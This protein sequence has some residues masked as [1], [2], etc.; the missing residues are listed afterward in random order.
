MG[1]KVNCQMDSQDKLLTMVKRSMKRQVSI[2]VILSEKFSRND[3]RKSLKDKI[4]TITGD[5]GAAEPVQKWVRI[6]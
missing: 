1:M 3:S 5:S 4:V 2:I 6:L